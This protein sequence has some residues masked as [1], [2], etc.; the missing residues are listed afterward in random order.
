LL[1]VYV[2]HS[3]VLTFGTPPGNNLEVYI[4]QWVYLVV[5]IL[6]SFVD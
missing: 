4:F 1:C 5:I 3:F 2:H 6:V